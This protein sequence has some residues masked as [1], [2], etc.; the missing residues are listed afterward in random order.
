MFIESL[1]LEEPSEIPEPE[2]N[3]PPMP[4]DL[5]PQPPGTVTPSPP[6]FQCLNTPSEKK[7]FPVYSLNLLSKSFAPDKM[8]HADLQVMIITQ[9]YWRMVVLLLL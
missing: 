5:I 4:T 3:P 1:R 2:S 8:T 6:G 7:S 9:L